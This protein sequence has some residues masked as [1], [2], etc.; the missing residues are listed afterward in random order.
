MLKKEWMWM[1]FNDE[2]NKEPDDIDDDT[3]YEDGVDERPEPT[4]TEYNDDEYDY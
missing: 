4:Q 3:E 1:Y 2:W